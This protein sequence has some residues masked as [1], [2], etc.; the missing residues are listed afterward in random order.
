M[1]GL[2][3]LHRWTECTEWYSN[4]TF[5][6]HSSAFLLQRI[7]F[8]NTILILQTFIHQHNPTHTL[9]E[10]HIHP[11]RG[12]SCR[13]WDE[14]G[15][16]RTSTVYLGLWPL[17]EIISA[18][19]ALRRRCFAKRV[20]V[21]MKSFHH[22]KK[23]SCVDLKDNWIILCFLVGFFLIDDSYSWAAVSVYFSITSSD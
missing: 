6:S 3:W 17:G 4:S 1:F 8:P 13:F 15:A 19:S 14:T 23:R 20:P 2:L 22:W 5:S 7:I 10:T 21:L 16:C 11:C 9:D 18:T 12:R